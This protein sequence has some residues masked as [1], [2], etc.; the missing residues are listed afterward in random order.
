MI[1]LYMVLI[2]WYHCFDYLHWNSGKISYMA[3]TKIIN[4]F[5]LQKK[6][7]FFAKSFQAQTT[8][9]MEYEEKNIQ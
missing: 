8:W 5:V 1:N 2:F 4:F 7:T 9:K 3:L 6:K